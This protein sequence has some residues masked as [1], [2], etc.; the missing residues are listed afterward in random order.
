MNQT[1][2]RPRIVVGVDG[3]PPSILALRWAGALAPLLQADIRVV[4]AWEFE[5]PHGR[6]TPAVADPDHVARGVCS[7]AVSKAFGSAPP[8]ALELVIRQ[9]PA[10]KVL[11]DESRQAQLLILGSRGLGALKGLLIGAVSAAVAE[12]AKCS[13]LIAHGTE[14]PPALAATPGTNWDHIP[15]TPGKGRNHAGV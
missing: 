6:L 7:E 1:E 3:S 11:V 15:K 4:T 9:G 13:V 8:S 10:T 14:L 12:H 2:K 5:I